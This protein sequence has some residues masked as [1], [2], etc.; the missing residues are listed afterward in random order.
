[1]GNPIWH[2]LVI[3]IAVIIPGG[4]LVYF[5]WRAYKFRKQSAEKKSKKI[6]PNLNNREGDDHVRAAITS[7][8]TSNNWNVN[9][10]HYMDHI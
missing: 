4:L 8:S 6:L 5:A 2:A 7:N 10:R 1:M 9:K 3:G